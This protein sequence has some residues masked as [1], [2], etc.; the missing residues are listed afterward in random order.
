VA[1]LFELVDGG[2]LDSVASQRGAFPEAAVAE[3]VAQALSRLAHLHARC[4]VHRDV[5]PANLLVTAGGGVKIANFGIAKVLS[6][7]G[8]HCATYEGTAAYMSPERFD[9]ERH[10]DADPCAAD[11]WGLAVTILELVMG[12][13]PLLRRDRSRP[14]RRSC[15]ASVSASCL[16]CRTA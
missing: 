7:A 3:V 14:G 8:D 13:Y 11:V 16:P 2:S 9:T 15:A 1:L 12:R 6:C 10:G 4:V 5:K